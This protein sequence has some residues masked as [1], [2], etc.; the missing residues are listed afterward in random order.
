MSY[1]IAGVKAIYL[2]A[3]LG[4]MMLA[5]AAAAQDAEAAGDAVET[6]QEIAEDMAPPRVQEAPTIPPPVPSVAMETAWSEERIDGEAF[7][8]RIGI[9]PADYPAEAWRNDEEGRVGFALAYDANGTITGCEIISSS[10]SQSLDEATCPLLYKR[11][12]VSFR[13]AETGEPGTKEGSYLWRKREPEFDVFRL[14]VAF[15]VDENGVA[16]ACEVIEASGKLPRGLERDM[17][18][19]PCPING[20]TIPYRDENGERVAK[21]LQLTFDVEELALET[22]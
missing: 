6:Q 2:S 5:G 16:G 13:S 7:L 21:R 22:E 11:A 20:G 15:T 12:Q 3:A 8:S 4:S 14:V 19:G 1:A 10:G 9:E 17:T 18:R